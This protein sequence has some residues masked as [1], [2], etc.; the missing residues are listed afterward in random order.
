VRVN[1][2]DH[3]ADGW[4][5]MEWRI[6]LSQPDA[7]VMQGGD[8]YIAGGLLGGGAAVSPVQAMGTL[9]PLVFR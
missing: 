1:D 5:E 8:F 3:L 7:G 9:L 2:P 6:C 4:S